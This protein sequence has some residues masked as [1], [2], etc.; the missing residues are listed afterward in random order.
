MQQ[1]FRQVITAVVGGFWKTK[2]NKILLVH[3]PAKFS[4]RHEHW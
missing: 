2:D 1:R 3:D 4:C